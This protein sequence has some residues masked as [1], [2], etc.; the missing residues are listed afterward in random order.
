MKMLRIALTLAFDRQTEAG[1]ERIWHDL[2]EQNLR[3]PST[4]YRPHITLAVYDVEDAER[5]H[6]KLHPFV[7]KFNRFPLRLDVLGMFP[8]RGVLFLTPRMTRPLMDFHR[9]VIQ[10][11]GDEVIA[12][13]LL[14]DCWMP[15]CTLA[16]SLAPAQMLQ[17]MRW[18]QANW[19]PLDAECQGM[20]ILVLPEN[21]DRWY[22]PLPR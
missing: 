1:I 7:G 3:G 4:A 12:A 18:C 5:F 8:E 22:S 2:D 9:A 11:F 10:T 14:P 19:R 6:E 20:G 16:V 17:A 13:H 15:H 21:E